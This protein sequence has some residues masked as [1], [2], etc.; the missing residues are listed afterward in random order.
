MKKRVYS[1]PKLTS[2]G[3][4][5]RLTKGGFGSDHLDATFPVGTPRGGLTFS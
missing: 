2:H 4:V 1:A 5:E 3:S